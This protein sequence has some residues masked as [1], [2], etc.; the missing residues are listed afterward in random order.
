MGFAPA[1]L[2]S[3]APHSCHRV[4]TT[5][6][7][8]I[9]ARSQPLHRTPLHPAAGSSG[10]SSLTP[11]AS[12]TA[13]YHVLAQR[14]MATV[15]AALGKGADSKKWAAAHDTLLAAYHHRY[16]NASVGGY[17][18]C[19]HD[20]PPAGTTGGG[21][22]PMAN[23]SCHGT[24]SKGSQ[25]SNALALALGAP[26]TKAI[27]QAVADNL[28]ADVVGFGNKTTTGVTGIAWLL[29]QLEQ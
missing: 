16:F 15:A 12:V 26:P 11:Q 14:Y 3:S 4:S 10:S 29:P 21:K 2:P 18:P 23:R 22:T 20:R 17:S 8:V 19:V 13:F 28:A 24:S 7:E 6:T 1:W 27:A 9:C 5:N 25:T